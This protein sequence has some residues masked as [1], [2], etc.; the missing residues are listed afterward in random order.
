QALSRLFKFEFQFR[1]DANFETIFSETL[2]AMEADGEL[3]KDEAGNV[4]LAPDGE[5]RERA[6][7]HHRMIRSFVEG[8]R[9][10]ARACATLRKGPMLPKEL[11]K[12][13]MTT[14]ERMFLA[15]E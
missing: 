13:A 3:V 9:I 4:R 8:Y 5:G 7:L 6:I 15:G 2:W 11:A 14:G 1:A 10:A 12:R